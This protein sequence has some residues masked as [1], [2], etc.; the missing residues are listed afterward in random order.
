MNALKLFISAWALLAVSCGERIVELRDQRNSAVENASVT[1]IDR[2]GNSV[3]RPSNIK[4]E[5]LF[6]GGKWSDYKEWISV[7][8]EVNNEIY[9]D[10]VVKS[11]DSNVIKIEIEL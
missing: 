8:V 7:K 11:P 10:K 5:V 3:S 2:N 6:G 4:G 9:Y 1:I